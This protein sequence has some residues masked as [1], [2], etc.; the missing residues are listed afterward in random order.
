MTVMSIV[1]G[2]LGM[3]NTGQGVRCRW[4][5]ESGNEVRG[6]HLTSSLL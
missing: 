5:V 4:K 1:D 6:V 3:T 2:L